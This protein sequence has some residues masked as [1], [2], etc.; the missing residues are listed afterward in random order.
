MVY[1]YEDNPFHKFGNK[2][3]KVA[4]IYDDSSSSLWNTGEFFKKI[5]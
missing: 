5:I 4:Y 2:L 1:I 3:R